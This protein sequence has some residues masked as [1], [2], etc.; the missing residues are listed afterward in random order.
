MWGRRDLNPQPIG[1]EP[2]ALTIELHPQK[3]EEGMGIEPMLGQHLWHMRYKLIGA[4]NYTNLPFKF[5]IEG[6]TRTLTPLLATDFKSVAS[7][8]SPLRHLAEVVGVEP[9]TKVLTGLRS[10]IEL[11]FS[12]SGMMGL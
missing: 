7:A 5:G 11:H 8:I 9:T 2:T 4:S 10:T 1:Y 3:V 12:R 6:G